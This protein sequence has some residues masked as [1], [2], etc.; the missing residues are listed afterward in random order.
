MNETII[1]DTVHKQTMV[2][3]G[4]KAQDVFT[5]EFRQFMSRNIMMTL[6]EKVKEIKSLP[7]EDTLC[8]LA[9]DT[10]TAAVERMNEGINTAIA[11]V[12]SEEFHKL[13]Q[14]G[15]EYLCEE[16]DKLFGSNGDQ[17]G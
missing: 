3:L 7:G 17:E 9:I 2:G 13:M 5:D 4:M 14:K 12:A 11:L 15:P 1:R 6:C 16:V 10:C 8:K